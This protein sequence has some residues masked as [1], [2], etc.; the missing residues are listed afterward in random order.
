MNNKTLV[1]DVAYIARSIITTERAFVIS[2]KGNAE[3]IHEYDE[4]FKLVNP[5]Y[6]FKKPSVIKVKKYVND[7]LHT[8]PLTRE[9]VYRRDNYSC[10]YCG[11]S[12]RKLLTLDHLV[13]KS[14]G[15]E[16]T[17][18]NLVTACKKCNNIKSDQSVDEFGYKI[19]K[20]YQP[21]YLM[22]MKSMF[23]IPEE[24]KKYLLF[25]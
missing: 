21:H 24:W 12:R 16:N 13:P 20:P 10:V 1:L 4:Y 2:M 7:L 6:Q 18:Q 15:G 25:Q 23:E 3:V 22:M 8:V 9:N 17:W 5:D 14:K 19:E 11:E